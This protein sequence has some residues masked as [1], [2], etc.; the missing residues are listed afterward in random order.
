MA[1][2]KAVHFGPI[3][4]S[5]AIVESKQDKQR[6]GRETGALAVDSVGD[7][8]IGGGFTTAGGV[9]ASRIAK[10]NGS[11]YSALG[12]GSPGLSVPSG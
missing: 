1:Q 10:W 11:T 6:I 8:Y 9:A 4:G 7:V 3:F 5:N 12:S 2:E